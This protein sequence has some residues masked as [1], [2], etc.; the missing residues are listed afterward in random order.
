MFGRLTLK[1]ESILF[2]TAV[3]FVSVCALGA[4]WWAYYKYFVDHSTTADQALNADL[5]AL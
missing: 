1:L 5:Q 4:G 3:S 2:F